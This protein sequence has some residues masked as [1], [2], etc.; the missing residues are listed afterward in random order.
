MDEALGQD[1]AARKAAL[2]VTRSFIVQAPA[3]SGKTGLLIQ[4]FLALLATAAQ[5]EAIV[6]MTF[7]RKAAGEI[8][9]RIIEAL[10]FALDAPEP[11]A[12]HEAMTWR[13]AR[14]VLERDAA[15]GW[16][17]LAHPA[18]LRILTIDA[19]CSALMRQAPLTVK[20][21]SLPRFVEHA[22]TLYTQ[23][24]LEDLNAAAQS[25]A[26][27]RTLL[28]HLDNDAER[29]V[30]LLAG[31]LGKRDQWLRH[32][33]T[34]DASGLRASL[35]QA[36]AVEIER[37]L[38][39]LEALFPPERVET[40]LEH[41][42]FAAANLSADGSMHPLGAFSTARTL[43]PPSAAAL[44]HWQTLAAWLLT[45][46]ATL[47]A[48]L[49]GAQGFPARG[50]A[51]GHGA[52]EHVA[53]KAAMESLLRELDA[54]PG[55]AAA[56]DRARRLPPPRYD[57]AGWAFV[58][59]LLDVLPRTAARLKV[60]FARENA[61]DFAEATLVALDAL[62]GDA[63]GDLLLAM[64][65]RIAHLLVDE[66]QDTSFAQ[67]ELVARLTAGWEPGDGRTLLLVGDPMQSIYGFREA[68]VGLFVTAQRDRRLGSVAL[69][70]LTL[71]RNF[72]S[73]P[74]LVEW[75]N[76]TFVHVL[77]ARDD[78]ARGA[79]AFKAAVATRGVGAM[80][81]VTLDVFS[82][83]QEEARAVVANIGA[84]L[85]NGAQTIAVLVRK[86]P[87]LEE[88]LPALRA[89]GI[90]FMAVGLDRL[91]ERPAMLDLLSLTH[92][93]LQPSDR[94]AWLSTL[95]APWCGLA[96][97]DLFVL[98]ELGPALPHVFT[99]AD[100]IHGIAGISPGGRVRLARFMRAIVPALG[101][102]GRTP[103]MPL[104]RGT[105]LALGGPACA[106]EAIDLTAADRFFALLAT[107]AK[108]GDVP[109][110]QALTDALA[111]LHLEPDARATARVQ[112]MTLHRAKGLEFDIVILPGLGRSPRG[113]DEQLL[114]W[115]ERASGLLLA[116]LNAR[117]PGAADGALYAYLRT[118]AADENAA[119]LGRLLYVG[120]TRA[121][122]KLHLIAQ[123]GIDDSLPEGRRWK[124]PAR[125]TSLAA[126]WPAVAREAPAPPRRPAGKPA[127]ASVATTGVPLQRL[128]IDWC[129]PPPPHAVPVSAGP[130]LSRE[131]EA[132]AFDWARETARHVGIVAHRLLLKIAE[133]GLH[134]WDRARVT[135]LQPRMQR[136]LAALGFTPEEAQTAAAQ[137]AEALAATLADPQGRWL[138]DPRHVDARSEY[139]LT[140]ER[141]GAL[142]RVV[143][144]R[145]FVDVRGIRWIVDF[146]L[147]RHEGADR[148]AFL[149]SERE[150][151]H[152]QLEDYARVMRGIDDRPI[153]AG[154]YFPLLRGWREW[155]VHA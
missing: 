28:D 22:D 13:L 74:G 39:I 80:P 116:P 94:L 106:R 131:R 145:T 6:A 9:E 147:S 111:A 102:R 107:H 12:A 125:G 76:R 72:R 128:A 29:V 23:A 77:P 45:R 153:R 20:Q 86:R 71:S 115:R 119:E 49:T 152:Q 143:L 3:G 62:G 36:I 79:V 142:V 133:D 58:A 52:A 127:T 110:W 129:L 85:Q 138:F 60:I 44:V 54:V 56:L 117:K 32:L 141:D 97:P 67:C 150:R 83:M 118:L 11:A 136:E 30:R 109:E 108:G 21:G 130:D 95:R 47:R 140:G 132:I 73:R 69:E 146:K 100:G 122:E 55:F 37:E 43:P 8:L 26:S 65:M 91:S 120:C 10:R 59:A 50:K 88:I 64:D 124:R 104:V 66:F 40:L 1:E 82:D 14:R 154:L 24:A 98:A 4:R 144:D 48:R 34:Q 148:E 101:Q 123:A 38:A 25:D 103:L 105:W 137:V 61:I 113:Q 16:N 35:E 155:E 46:T 93:L 121:R 70:V 89:S 42:R 41:V 15:R 92:A 149:D 151:Y 75:V 63:P 18:R 114:L 31:M 99:R 57:A 19:L 2:D 51:S 96:L 5:P 126:L 90:D 134:Q 112:I 139:A 68:N 81:A 84:A 78:P 87:D 7:T 53:R 27:W 33:V 135:A 17:L